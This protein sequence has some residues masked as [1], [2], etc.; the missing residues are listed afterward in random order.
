M[1]D[2]KKTALWDAVCKSESKYTKKVTLGK[3]AYTTIDAQSQL[4][5]ATAQF[6]S[7]GHTWGLKNIEYSYIE[8]H[9]EQKLAVV[10]ADFYAPDISFPLT[11][12]IMFVTDGKFGLKVDDD[13]AKKIETDILTKALSKIG[14]NAD[15]FL[16]KFDDARYVATLKQ[17]ELLSELKDKEKK[18]LASLAKTSTR[19]EIVELWRAN[20]ELQNEE[21]VKSEVNKKN[22]EIALLNN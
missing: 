8:L 17:D 9:K 22:A 18:F 3:R 13:F 4:L 2:K 11:S 21:T 20:P 1:E 15:V 7:Y 12:S 10:S 6:G 5:K 19:E 14:F 16:G